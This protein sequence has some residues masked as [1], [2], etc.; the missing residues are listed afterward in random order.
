MT[1]EIL[2]HRDLAAVAGVGGVVDLDAAGDVVLG[3]QGFILALENLLGD[4]QVEGVRTGAGAEG[5]HQDAV[6]GLGH[7]QGGSQ[8]DDGRTGVGVAND[9]NQQSGLDLLGAEA[10]HLCGPLREFGVGLVEDGVLVVFGGHAQR[11][12][13]RACG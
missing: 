9:R 1:F 4:G 11:F 12:H 3:F 13:Q 2:F 6:A 10:Q 5:D 7:V 8:A